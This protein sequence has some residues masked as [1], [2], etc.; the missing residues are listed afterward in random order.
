MSWCIG[1]LKGKPVFIGSIV[2]HDDAGLLMVRGIDRCFTTLENT[3]YTFFEVEGISGSSNK[4]EWPKTYVTSV[5][6]FDG[7]AA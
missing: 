2:D 5:D 6:C 1:V 4:L 3:Y 7:R